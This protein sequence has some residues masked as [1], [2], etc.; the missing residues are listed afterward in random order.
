MPMTEVSHVELPDFS[1][2]SLT[3]ISTFASDAYSRNNWHTHRS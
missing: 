3:A 2:S 1:R